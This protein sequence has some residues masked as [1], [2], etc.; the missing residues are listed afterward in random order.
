MRELAELT[1]VDDAAWPELLAELSEAAVS[2]G[3][4][5]V[6]ADVAAATLVQLQ[7]TAR[8]YLGAVVLHS[9]GFMVDD[10]WVRIYGSPAAG[11]PWGLPS[12]AT[13]N[14]FPAVVRSGWAPA[15][16]LIIAHDVLGGVFALNGAN[17]EAYGH[18]GDPGEVIY[19]AP[20]SLEWAPLECGHTDWLSWLLSGGHEGFYADV[21][22]PS[23][24]DAT[25]ELHGGQGLSVAPFLWTEEAMRNPA[26]CSR[27]TVPMTE[28]LGVNRD[29]CAQLT[30]LDPGFLG[31][32]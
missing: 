4:V 25:R 27:R 11:N 1:N 19:F 17:P 13:V 3:A 30:G 24:R 21:R 2:V 16:G 18:P 29:F 32:V 22:W 9:G 20:E 26:A 14:R 6:D 5:P 28:L 12:L 15:E 31:V 10:G 7:V 23:W 8:S